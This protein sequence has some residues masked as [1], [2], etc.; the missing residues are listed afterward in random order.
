MKIRKSFVSNS[1]SASFILDKRFITPDQI[2]QLIEYNDKN[3]DEGGCYDSWS[4]REDENFVRGF[5]I[6]DNE[7]L[8]EWIKENLII[9]VQAIVE[10]GDY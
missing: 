7:Y 5:T 10:W 4:I 9:P 8:L 3:Y 2:R 6:M 1:S